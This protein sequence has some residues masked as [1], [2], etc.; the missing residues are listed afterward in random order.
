MAVKDNFGF[1]KVQLKR[2]YSNQVLGRYLVREPTLKLQI[3]ELF[4]ILF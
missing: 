2:R 3:P 1:G 4:N